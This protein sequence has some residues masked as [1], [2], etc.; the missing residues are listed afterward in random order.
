MKDK[1][2]PKE[3]LGI[4]YGIPCNCGR[5]YIGETGRCLS[6]RLRE[7]QRA[8]KLL[9]TKNALATHIMEYPDHSIEWEKATVKDY[10]A[11]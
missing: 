7:Y 6:I 2:P 9:D 1:P 3:R 10:E 4:V 11:N 8:V 5:L